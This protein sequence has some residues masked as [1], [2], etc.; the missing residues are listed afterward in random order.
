MKLKSLMYTS[1]ASP[2]LRSGEVDSILEAARTNNPLQGLSGV[3]IFNGSHFLQILEGVEPAVDELVG[4]L[5][6]DKR[7]S[8][9]SIRDERWITQRIF[10]DWAMA[11]LLLKNDQFVGEA[12]VERLL[13]RDLPESLRNLI[14]GLTHSFIPS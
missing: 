14:R 5:K 9:M 3:L 13:Q 10:P 12:E 2:G 4:R 1:W 7:H 11:Y 8:N 6:V